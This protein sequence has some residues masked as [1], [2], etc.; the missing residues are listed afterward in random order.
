MTVLVIVAVAAGAFFYFW[1]RMRIPAPEPPAPQVQNAAVQQDL[2]VEPLQVNLY[3][4][5]NGALA[6]LPAGIERQPDLQL[7]AREAAAAVFSGQHGPLAPVLKDLK[8]RAFYLDG[9]GTAF[10]DLT[11][12]HPFQK[13]IAASAWDELLALYALV[14]TLTG[15]FE[16]IREVRFLYDGRE[17]QTLAGH[18]DLTKSYGKRTDLVKP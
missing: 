18:L 6:A 2:T 1:Y 3:V 7:Q 5:A 17:T 9:S 15:N 14:N 11:S 8:L 12:S 4:P 10:V 16:E 13:E